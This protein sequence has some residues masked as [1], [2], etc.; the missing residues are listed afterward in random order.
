MTGD[1]L[2][3]IALVISSATVVAAA[4]YLIVQAFS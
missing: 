1:G 4:I 3:I 2:L